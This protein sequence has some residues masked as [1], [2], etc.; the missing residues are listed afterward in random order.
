MIK[1]MKEFF[2][3]NLFIALVALPFLFLLTLLGI[4]EMAFIFNWFK[5]L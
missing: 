5:S 2:L 1:M 3:L 4:S